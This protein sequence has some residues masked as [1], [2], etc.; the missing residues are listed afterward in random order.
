M[1]TVKCL[2]DGEVRMSMKRNV[3]C[4]TTFLA[5]S[6]AIRLFVSF[7]SLASAGEEIPTHN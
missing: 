6:L 2:K 3:I 7:L 1:K 5:S 4:E